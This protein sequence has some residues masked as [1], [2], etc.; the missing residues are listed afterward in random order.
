MVKIS[1]L[2]GSFAVAQAGYVLQTS[3]K[4][5]MPITSSAD[6]AKAAAAIRL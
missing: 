1:M 4:C 2:L 3:G 5:A 6:C